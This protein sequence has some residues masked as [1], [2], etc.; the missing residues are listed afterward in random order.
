MIDKEINILDT[1]T[2]YI[3]IANALAGCQLVENELK[4]YISM[5]YECINI[6]IDN[7]IPFSMSENDLKG[8]KLYN[9]IKIFEKLSD[10]AELVS[11]LEA[12]SKSRNKFAHSGI[13]NCLDNDGELY[14]PTTIRFEAE[15]KAL[16]Q[17]AN[18]LIR[19]IH[20]ESHKFIDYIYGD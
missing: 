11:K 10:N 17:I 13:F 6:F 3:N 5:A 8:Q 12:F 4:K 15:I 16:R 9:L 1:D 2:F 14:L 7:R 18:D 19:D 20:I